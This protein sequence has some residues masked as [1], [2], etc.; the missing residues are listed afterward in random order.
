MPTCGTQKP[1]KD[2]NQ[3]RKP[4]CLGIENRGE[5]GRIFNPERFCSYPRPKRERRNAILR[6]QSTQNNGATGVGPG[7]RGGRGASQGHAQ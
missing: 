2:A 7:R 6:S 1:S 4:V 3:I 5:S